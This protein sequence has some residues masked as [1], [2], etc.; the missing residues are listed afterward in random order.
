[1]LKKSIV[2][3]LFFLLLAHNAYSE[4]NVLD[5]YI[6]LGL[7]NNLA[8]QQQEFQFEKSMEALKEARGMFLPSI[9]LMG[10]F[11]RA[12]GGRVFE[13]PVGDLINP[14]NTAFNQLYSFHGIDA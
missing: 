8:L 12:G 5:Q 6:A 1:M 14:I 13:I 10:R 9:H 7:Q 4:Q 3:S 2:L 11:S